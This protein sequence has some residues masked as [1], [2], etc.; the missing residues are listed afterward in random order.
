MKRQS[1]TIALRPI[2][3]LMAPPPLYF[4]VAFGIGALIQTHWP[5]ALSP[6]P[7][8]LSVIGSFTIAAGLIL[9]LSLVSTFLIRRTTLNPFAEPS[10]FLAAGPYRLSRNP[11]YLSVIIVY[12]GG[13]LLFGSLWPLLTIV[14]PLLI[15]ARAVV[16]YE[17]ARMAATFG[18][19]Y[20]SYCQRVRRWI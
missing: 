16:P 14:A 5:A 12:L 8:A 4:G 18:E 15:L 3:P 19:A 2:A 17:E 11:M 6:V 7:E 1:S 10:V 20:S 13:T 9:A